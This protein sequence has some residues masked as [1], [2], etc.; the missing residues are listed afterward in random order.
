MNQILCSTG[1]YASSRDPGCIDVI[2]K[3]GS[4]LDVD[5][6]ELIM[7][8]GWYKDAQEIGRTL[9]RSG[10][11]FP[12]MHAEKDLSAFFSV[13]DFDL[14]RIGMERFETNCRLACML[15][16]GIIVLH[17]WTLPDSDMNLERNISMLDELVSTA[18]KYDLL[19]TIETVPCIK[20][21]PMTNIKE[22]FDDRCDLKVTLDTRL[23]AVHDQ[24]DDLGSANWFW[25][26][27]L[28]AHVHI[29]DY[30]G[31][32]ESMR[33]PLMPGEGCIDFKSFFDLLKRKGYKG[34]LTLESRGINSDKEIDERKIAKGISFIRDGIL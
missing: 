20:K 3:F 30:S 9:R 26:M 18:G 23:L 12:V 34:A 33:T 24:L 31:I 2:S 19:L 28:A 13:E 10:I 16:A 5:G 17:L 8:S 25:D 4:K 14:Q 1:V 6:L 27:D 22:I 32:F 15:K 29:S 21:D 7:Y 11:P